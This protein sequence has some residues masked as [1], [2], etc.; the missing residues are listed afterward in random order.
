MAWWKDVSRPSPVEGAL[1]QS[2]GGGGM[3]VQ[4][5]R[6]GGSFQG[7]RG[8]GGWRHVQLE[9]GIYVGHHSI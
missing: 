7:G 3:L 1:D 4:V 6:G 5:E 8:G 2:L 9:K